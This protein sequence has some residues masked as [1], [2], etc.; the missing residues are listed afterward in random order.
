MKFEHKWKKKLI[1][2]TLNEKYEST[3]MEKSPRLNPLFYRSHRLYSL[4]KFI[5]DPEK[6]DP[7]YEKYTVIND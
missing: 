2:L 4:Y 5:L 1:L 3:S 7:I 6:L